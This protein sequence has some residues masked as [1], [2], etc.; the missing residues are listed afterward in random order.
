MPMF[1]AGGSPY[2]VARTDRA[3]RLPFDLYPSATGSNDKKLSKGMHMPAGARSWLKGNLGAAEPCAAGTAE[4][5]GD[6]DGAGEVA[7]RQ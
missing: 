3:H 6:R 2:E 7:G 1:R 5:L 4:R